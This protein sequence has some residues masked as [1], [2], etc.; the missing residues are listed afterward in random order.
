MSPLPYPPAH[1]PT[2][3]TPKAVRPS[4]LA[5]GPGQR[6]LLGGAIAGRSRES[7]AGKRHARDLEVQH[8]P[9]PKKDL[10]PSRSIDLYESEL[11]KHINL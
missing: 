9:N 10:K 4:A 6:R 11:F 7:Q 1:P 3:P 2:N 8:N 5:G